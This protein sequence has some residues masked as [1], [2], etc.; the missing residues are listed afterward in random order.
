M[1]T[2]HFVALT[3]YTV[4][5]WYQTITHLLMFP[6]S[7]FFTNS[8]SW[9][10]LARGCFRH[11]NAVSMIDTLPTHCSYTEESECNFKICTVVHWSWFKVFIVP[12]S[13]PRKQIFYR[14]F[15]NQYLILSIIWANS[16]PYNSQ[17]GKWM[18]CYSILLSPCQ[19]PVEYIN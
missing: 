3:I 10:Y 4:T 11:W 19:T 14:P 5:Y 9:Y 13:L 18:L 12:I 17:Y 15:I 2:L 16:S 6:S 8:K 1:K 7:L